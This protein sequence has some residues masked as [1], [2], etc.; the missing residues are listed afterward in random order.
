[1]S[2]NKTTCYPVIGD[3]FY[4]VEWG[5]GSAR[6]FRVFWF[7]DQDFTKFSNRLDRE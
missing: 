1:M 6:Y 4:K 5:S 7:I 3:D 2:P